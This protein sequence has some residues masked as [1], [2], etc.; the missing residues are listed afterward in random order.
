MGREL[1]RLWQQFML[2]I[3]PDGG[4]YRLLMPMLSRSMYISLVV[5]MA[6]CRDSIT[7][8][9]RASSA[10]KSPILPSWVQ[11]RGLKIHANKSMKNFCQEAAALGMSLSTITCAQVKAKTSPNKKATLKSHACWPRGRGKSKKN[12]ICNTAGQCLLISLLCQDLREQALFR[13]QSTKL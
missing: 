9:R 7:G 4:R 11:I 13:V 12:G 3:F 2:V 5:S 1:S 6:S 10:S 8:T